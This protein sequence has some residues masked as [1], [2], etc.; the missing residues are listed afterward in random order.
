MSGCPLIHFL[1]PNIGLS[2]ESGAVGSILTVTGSGFAGSSEITVIYDAIPIACDTHNGTTSTF[3]TTFKIPQS[4]AGSHTIIVKDAAGHSASG[5]FTVIPEITI[6]PYQ[7]KVNDE[8]NIT[9]VTD[10]PN[11]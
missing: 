7:G 6:S 1:K 10:V 11:S 3:T 8:T 4:V 2:L 5:T 9:G